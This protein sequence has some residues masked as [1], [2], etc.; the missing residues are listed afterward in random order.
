[1]LEN[2]FPIVVV[3]PTPPVLLFRGRGRSSPVRTIAALSLCLLSLLGSQD[4]NRRFPCE[5]RVL[6]EK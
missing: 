1:M 3:P 2:H 5:G 6:Q 4:V